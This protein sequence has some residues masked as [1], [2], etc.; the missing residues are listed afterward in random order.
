MTMA[1]NEPERLINRAGPDSTATPP[2][3]RHRGRRLTGR[4]GTQRVHAETAGL[5]RQICL[6]CPEENDLVLRILA[7]IEIRAGLHGISVTGIIC[8]DSAV[9]APSEG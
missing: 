7:G 1:G 6:P 3:E 4:S 9:Q 2:E 8:T 5:R